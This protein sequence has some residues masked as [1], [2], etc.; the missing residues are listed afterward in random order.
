MEQP[1]TVAMA[2]DHPVITERWRPGSGPIR[3]AVAAG[4]DG[5]HAYVSKEEGNPRRIRRSARS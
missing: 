4:V 2:E 1:V 5:A 3:P